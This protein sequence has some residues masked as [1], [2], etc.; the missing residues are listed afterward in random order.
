MTHR[1]CLAGVMVGD[2]VSIAVVGALNV[3]PESFFAGSIVTR[4]D[5]LLRAAQAM[6][7]AGAALLDVGAMS[8]APYLPTRISEAEEADRLGSAVGLLAGKIDVPISADTSRSLPAQ[9]ALEAGAR[10]IN[11]VTGLTG[12][13]DL[14]GV[15][16]RGGAGLI[17]MASERSGVRPSA[18]ETAD[19]S[20]SAPR[21]PIA[22]VSALLAESLEV[23]RR[24]G[25]ASDA[26]VDRS[27]HRLLQTG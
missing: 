6:V 15:V 16:A 5:Q 23:A 9:R 26:I 18:R 8:T 13:A 10:I 20:R 1:S 27:R 22:V 25:I 12:D 4:G 17:A 3:S 14:A 7:Q 21:D 24:A 11:D 19:C 2:G